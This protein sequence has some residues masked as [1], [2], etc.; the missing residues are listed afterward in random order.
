MPQQQNNQGRHL[1]ALHSHSPDPNSQGPSTA[2]GLQMSIISTTLQKGP[3][4]FV[5]RPRQPLSPALRTLQFGPPT[6]HLGRNVLS[7]GG[8]VVATCPV[9]TA[10]LYAV[11]AC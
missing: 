10:A 11:T 9:S 4:R 3:I 2:A 6:K 5:G 7:S 1:Q 8:H